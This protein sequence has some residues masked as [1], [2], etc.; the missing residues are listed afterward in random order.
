MMEQEGEVN[1]DDLM[2]YVSGRKQVIATSYLCSM[3]P[4]I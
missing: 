4:I 3:K 2:K 1:S